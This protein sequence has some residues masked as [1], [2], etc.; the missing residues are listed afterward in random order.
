[1]HQWLQSKIFFVGGEKAGKSTLSC[2]LFPLKGYFFTPKKKFFTFNGVH[3][4]E[5]SDETDTKPIPH[6]VDEEWTLT[7][8][9]GKDF[10]IELEEKYGTR[11][12]TLETPD[13]KLGLDFSSYFR[14]I[15]HSERTGLQIR[16]I[17]MSSEKIEKAKHLTLS[18][19]DFGGGEDFYQSQHHFISPGTIFVITYPLNTG[20]KALTEL[21]FWI[22][23]LV[24]HLSQ[25]P[26]ME[27]RYSVFIVGTML[28]ERGVSRELSD[29]RKKGVKRL[30]EECGLKAKFYYQEVSCESQEN[31]SQLK[32]KIVDSVLA[33][34]HVGE[35][36]P[37]SYLEVR[38]ALIEGRKKF[39]DIPHQNLE[40]FKKEL[41]SQ[42]FMEDDRLRD[43]LDLLRDLGQCIFFSSVSELGDNL[44]LDP[45]FFVTCAATVFTHKRYLERGRLKHTDLEKIWDH[46]KMQKG[47][48]Y[49]LLVATMEKYEILFQYPEEE[50][51]NFFDQISII[52]ALLPDKTIEE[53]L[54]GSSE[55][56]L[57]KKWPKEL[58]KSHFENL[59]YLV[60]NTI[61]GEFVSQVLCRLKHILVRDHLWNKICLVE[62]D[63]TFG[64]VQFFTEDNEILIKCRGLDQSSTLSMID[65]VIAV[66][67]ETT[68]LHAGLDWNRSVPS[69]PCPQAL[70]SLTEAEEERKKPL[71]ERRFRCPKTYI[72]IV[73]ESLLHQYRLEESPEPVQG[74]FYLHSFLLSSSFHNS[75]FLLKEN[76]W[77]EL[78]QGEHVITFEQD[79]TKQEKVRAAI[80]TVLKSLKIDANKLEIAHFHSVP[81][82]HRR[83]RE[84]RENLSRR[85][86]ESPA[87]YN[88]KS[89]QDQDLDEKAT[90]ISHLYSIISEF[91]EGNINSGQKSFIVP[92]FY[93][94]SADH[95]DQVFKK[96]E[97][98]HQPGPFGKGSIIY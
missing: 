22:R 72:P 89:W 63:E 17:D 12:L 27:K 18:V 73:P 80:F 50:N 93:V 51:K 60:F 30:A 55:P 43:I 35:F 36:F 24:S 91:R 31:I 2:S 64:L 42:L 87:E 10:Q 20:R 19:W 3:L 1:M 56:Q 39:P 45:G 81:A 96:G 34:H 44:F 38:R 16:T 29:V 69:P 86:A 75:T 47:Y 21:E 90:V 13:K 61:P 85:Q 5:Y 77:W 54:E 26:G 4:L 15:I 11:K 74:F 8:R 9:D 40:T 62:K 23:S 32:N 33:S 48:L 83:F 14:H 7:Q 68:R 49:Q 59:H 78:S 84:Y 46:L 98:H 28:D 82:L 97:F 53:L 79:D 41:P 70:V 95:L 37:Q 94:V 65:C 92:V 58:P 52:P 67:E 6:E 71:P 57:S 76:A 66:I 25:E 88:S